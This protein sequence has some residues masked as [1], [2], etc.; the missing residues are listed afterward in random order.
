M[1]S[2]LGLLLRFLAAGLAAAPVAAATT[3]L[4][5][6]LRIF[7]DGQQPQVRMLTCT[8]HARNHIVVVQGHSGFAGQQQATFT[9]LLDSNAGTCLISVD[10]P[11]D[12]ATSDIDWFLPNWAVETQ[13]EFEAQLHFQI[14]PASPMPRS[15]I[16]GTLTS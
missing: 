11:I 2:F 6:E 15:S 4:S 10:P 8:A 3:P 7:F 12:P 16:P 13:A 1:R 9:T 5:I 14:A